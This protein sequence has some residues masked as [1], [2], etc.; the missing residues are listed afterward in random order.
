V[1]DNVINNAQLRDMFLKFLE[2]ECYPQ[3]LTFV[4]QMAKFSK[5]GNPQ[6]IYD[7]YVDQS[8]ATALEIPSS[9]RGKF[10]TATRDSCVDFLMEL[11]VI[12][13]EELRGD[14]LD[15][16][17]TTPT[18]VEEGIKL[19]PFTFTMQMDFDDADEKTLTRGKS[20]PRMIREPLTSRKSKSEMDGPRLVSEG[21]NIS[22]FVFNKK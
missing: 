18:F 1:L 13:T 8:S 20:T 11:Y 15:N 7:T 2:K 21:S 12:V 4:E 6:L 3:A 5:N 9:L 19:L 17:I 14:R 10:E 16:F 22:N